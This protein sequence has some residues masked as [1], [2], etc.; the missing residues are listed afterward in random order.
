ML[1]QNS[2]YLPNRIGWIYPKG[3]IAP[4]HPLL[5]AIHQ[6]KQDLL[7]EYSFSEIGPDM[8]TFA[9]G[10]FT[11]KLARK[12]GLVQELN[13]IEE[14]LKQYQH[15]KGT[16]R[17]AL[18]PVIKEAYKAVNHKFSAVLSRYISRGGT[19]GPVLSARGG[20]KAALKGRTTITN[21]SR[22][23]P[24]LNAAKGLN[25]V[26]KGLVVLDLGFRVKNVYQSNNMGRTAVSEFFGLGASALT[27]YIG[28]AIAASL[29]L[30]PLG[31]L[32]AIVVVG[33]TVVATDYLGKTFGN[34]VYDQSASLY[35]YSRTNFAY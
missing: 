31:W 1:T 30:G 23:R 20:M 32:V 35:Q 19:K 22:A 18:K 13:A 9:G 29:V 6:L 14:L 8:N 17:V 16:E 11:A 2:N 27:G 15:A 33:A 10:A 12:E 21:S 25:Y 34:F 28:G 24:L 3:T 26:T 5:Q 7:P 4:A